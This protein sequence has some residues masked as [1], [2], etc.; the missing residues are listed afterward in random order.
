M[1]QDKT[2][3]IYLSSFTFN[4]TKFACIFCVRIQTAC[5]LIEKEKK[6]Y[7]DKKVKI[8]NQTVKPTA[9]N[10]RVVSLLKINLLPDIMYKSLE[11]F[12]DL[13]FSCFNGQ[14]FN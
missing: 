3:M 5:V 6:V 8:N 14:I 2:L 4:F 10:Y 9:K 12:L 13:L 11:V 7:V 1:L